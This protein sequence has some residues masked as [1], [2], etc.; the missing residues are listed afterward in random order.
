MQGFAQGLITTHIHDEAETTM[1]EHQG[2]PKLVTL[3]EEAYEGV[4]T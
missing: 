4:S 1:K 3:L 2:M